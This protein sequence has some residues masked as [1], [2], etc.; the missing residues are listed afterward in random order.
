MW[1]GVSAVLTATDVGGSLV[2][3]FVVFGTNLQTTLIFEREQVVERFL[4]SVRNDSGGEVV[5]SDFASGGDSVHERFHLVCEG[6]T[7]GHNNPFGKIA[8]AILKQFCDNR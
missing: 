4:V 3:R 1:E 8:Y 5:I 7:A 6:Q 2:C